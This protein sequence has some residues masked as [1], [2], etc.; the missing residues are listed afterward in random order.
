MVIA[1]DAKS[2][3]SIKQFITV[4]CCILNDE[5]FI[6]QFSAFSASAAA[7]SAGSIFNRSKIALTVKTLFFH[8]WLVAQDCNS[9]YN[10][11]KKT[12]SSEHK[13][14]FNI[15]VVTLLIELVVFFPSR[16]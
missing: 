4:H 12:D 8:N 7:S 5:C 15:I 11:K 14:I 6:D 1:V 13:R 3:T 2:D 10:T 9:S 16:L